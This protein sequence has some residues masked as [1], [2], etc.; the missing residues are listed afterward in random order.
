MYVCLNLIVMGSGSVSRVTKMSGF[1]LD[2]SSFSNQIHL[3]LGFGYMGGPNWQ[4]VLLFP[5]PI[6]TT[7]SEFSLFKEE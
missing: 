6:T 4:F 5:K 2:F 3:R 1:P 7:W